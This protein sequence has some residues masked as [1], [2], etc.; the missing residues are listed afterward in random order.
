MRTHPTAGFSFPVAKH[1]YLTNKAG[2][3]FYRIYPVL[4]RSRYK[5]DEEEDYQYDL[6]NPLPQFDTHITVTDLYGEFLT[7][8]NEKGLTVELLQRGE[9][10]I[11]CSLTGH[12][13]QRALNSRILIV[14]PDEIYNYPFKQRRV[15]SISLTQVKDITP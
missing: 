7:K 6:F 14:V 9:Y 10:L 12:Q 4:P 11:T 8:Y 13:E 2:G 3:Y 5:K 1:I 15:Y